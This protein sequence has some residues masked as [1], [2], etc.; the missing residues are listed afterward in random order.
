MTPDIYDMA[1][2]QETQL[3]YHALEIHVNMDIAQD[4]LLE[5]LNKLEY[6]FS[7]FKSP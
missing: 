3:R 2:E 1:L 4:E 6:K 5:K 7:D